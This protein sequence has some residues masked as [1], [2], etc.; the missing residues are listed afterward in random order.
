MSTVPSPAFFATR[1][2]TVLTAKPV[3]AAE[4][5]GGA[6]ART[7]RPGLIQKRVEVTHDGIVKAKHLQPGQVVRAY[8]KGEPRGGVRVVESVERLDDGAFVEVTFSSDDPTTVYKAAYRFFVADLVGT[9]LR[10]KV[11]STP[12]LVAYEEV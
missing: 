12:A 7:V 4:T 3:V 11:V 10:H 5:E 6:P 1:K 2:P 8:I 9:T